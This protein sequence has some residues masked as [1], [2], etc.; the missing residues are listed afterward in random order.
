MYSAPAGAG[1]SIFRSV[2]ETRNRDDFRDFV[3]TPRVTSRHAF[4][5]IL[6]CQRLAGESGGLVSMQIPGIH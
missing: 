5:K 6:I 4:A 3:Q 2:S 1:F